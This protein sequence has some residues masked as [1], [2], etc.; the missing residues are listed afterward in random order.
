[1]LTPLVRAIAVAAPPPSLGDN[2]G[3]LDRLKKVLAPRAGYAG[4]ALPAAEQ[5]GRAVSR[6][7]RLCGRGHYQ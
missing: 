3:D 6:S 5:G 1:M 4:G 7:P 2:T